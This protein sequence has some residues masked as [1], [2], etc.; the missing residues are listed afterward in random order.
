[1]EASPDVTM[2]SLPSLY[3][4]AGFHVVRSLEVAPTGRPGYFTGAQIKPPKDSFNIRQAV[5]MPTTKRYRV[6]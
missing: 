6:T 2:G 1:M 4:L 5:P 3:S